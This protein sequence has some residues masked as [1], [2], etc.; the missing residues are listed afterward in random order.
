MRFKDMTA[1][2]AGGAGGIGRAISKALATEGANVVIWDLNETLLKEAKQEI[3]DHNGSVSTMLVDVSDYNKVKE[4]V[5]KVVEE[6]GK[7]HMMVVTVG[8]GQFKPF[9]EYTPD[10]WHKQINYNLNTV[11]NCFHVALQTMVKQT[12]GRL[13]CFTSSLG[14]TPGLA[15]YQSGK[16]AC[17]SLIETIS[18]EHGKD[19]ITANS[20]MPGMVLTSLTLKAFDRPGGEE[21]LKQSIKNLP[22]GENT[23]ENVAR[24]ALNILEDERIAGQVI[25][26]R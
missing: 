17:K 20:I 2:V 8:G 26:L 19:N 21:Q 16:A 13:L 18:A 1:I 10:F 12:F 4:S 11:F 14:G 5:D 7:L 6:T 25:S 24:T 22:M 3:L 9:I 15:A 23:V